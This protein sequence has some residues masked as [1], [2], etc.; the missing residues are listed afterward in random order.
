ML[1]LTRNFLHGFGV[2]NDFDYV[3]SLAVLVAD[4]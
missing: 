1:R 4:V 2:G 3:D